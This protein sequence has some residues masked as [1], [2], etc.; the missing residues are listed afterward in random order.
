MNYKKVH[1][2]IVRYSIHIIYHAPSLGVKE[3]LHFSAEFARVAALT[4]QN[5]WFSGFRRVAGDYYKN[6]YLFTVAIALWDLARLAYLV[7]IR[8]GTS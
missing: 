7:Y 1:L 3:I 8:D 4:L 6:V 5:Q 2:F